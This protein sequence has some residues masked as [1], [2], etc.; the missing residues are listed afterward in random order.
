MKYIKHYTVKWHDTDAN[1]N[2]T[3]SHL[4]M[5]MEE[6]SDHHLRDAGMSLDDL[7][8]RKSLA[9][10][11]SRI[12]VRS[13]LQLHAGDAIDVETWV[14]EGR[15]LSFIRC[16]RV[17]R[18][19]EVAAEAYSVW[20]LL[21]LGTRKLLPA[22]EFPYDIEPE[23]PLCS[24]VSSRVRFP[25]QSGMELA[26]ERKIVYS[27]IDYN[28]HMNNTHYPNMLCDFT[29]DI[30]SKQI[31]GFTLSFLHEASFGHTLQV[32]R[33]QTSDGYGFRTLD[34]DGNTCLE[35]MLFTEPLA[36]VA[37]PEHQV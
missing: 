20:A 5:Y 28:G 1:R 17:L 9:F 23:L 32:W 29:P 14:C 10:L 18:A 37:I 13:Y 2:L 12:A 24:S 21:H 34:E 35:A 30:R 3:P 4:L 6:T 22:S 7:R 26:G 25:A 15:G 33:Q 8:D 31:V 36:D 19:G 16:F 27:D 11:L